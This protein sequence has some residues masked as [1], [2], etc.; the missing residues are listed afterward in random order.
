MREREVTPI[1][2]PL[3]CCH[4]SKSFIRI[5]LESDILQLCEYQSKNKRREKNLILSINFQTQPAKAIDLDTR[6]SLLEISFWTFESFGPLSKKMHCRVCKREKERHFLRSSGQGNTVGVV[7][8]SQ[9]KRCHFP[10][11]MINRKGSHSHG[12]QRRRRG[13]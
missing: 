10:K 6:W 4:K 9:R 3:Y 8:L 12:T 1:Y 13:N 7:S 2:H 5:Q 11:K